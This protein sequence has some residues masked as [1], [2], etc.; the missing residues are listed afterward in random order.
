MKDQLFLKWIHDRLEYVYKED[1]N[2]DYM[3]KLRSIIY[4]TDPE[5]ISKN[6]TQEEDKKVFR[7]VV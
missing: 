2:I 1:R 3:H 6:L 5:Q 7:M 4:N